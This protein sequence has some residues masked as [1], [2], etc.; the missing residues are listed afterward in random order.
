MVSLC[1]FKHKD[2]P[3]GCSKILFF[4]IPAGSLSANTFTGN[5][6]LI[7]NVFILHL[8][9][10]SAPAELLTA[11]VLTQKEAI[12]CLSLKKNLM[13]R[14]PLPIQHT[15]RWTQVLSAHCL[16]PCQRKKWP[17]GV[18]QGLEPASLPCL[19]GASNPF[20]PGE[21]PT[22]HWSLQRLRRG[23][24]VFFSPRLKFVFELQ[25]PPKKLI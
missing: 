7:H 13:L 12:F 23:K 5:C 22:P 25:N 17:P 11:L 14:Y 6:P 1:D 2:G 3:W 16:N 24:D 19:G 8:R 9:S 10:I 21:H 20:P 15:P 18:A 4:K